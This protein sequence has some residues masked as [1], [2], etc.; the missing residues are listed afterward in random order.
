MLIILLLENVH[1]QANMEIKRFDS[2]VFYNFL[3]LLSLIYSLFSLN[4]FAIVLRRGKHD[5]YFGFALV[6][7]SII[8][9]IIIIIIKD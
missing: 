6:L 1:Q 4:F 7:L 5:L 3:I 2:Y 8:I 9:I